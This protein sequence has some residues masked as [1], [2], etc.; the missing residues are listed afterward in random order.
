MQIKNKNSEFI[1][2]FVGRIINVSHSGFEAACSPV[3]GRYDW[4]INTPGA[5]GGPDWRFCK[6]YSFPA[7]TNSHIIGDYTGP[8]VGG[9]KFYNLHLM[10]GCPWVNFW[11][12]SNQN[13]V[14]DS[15]THIVDTENE[16]KVWL[17]V[18]QETGTGYLPVTYGIDTFDVTPRRLQNFKLVPGAQYEAKNI[19][20]TGLVFQ[21]K[22]LQV[23]ADGLLTFPDFICLANGNWLQIRNTTVPTEMKQ[24]E[25]KVT[26]AYIL[27]PNA[28]NP[29]NPSTRIAYRVVD[30]GGNSSAKP[31]VI[32]IYDSAGRSVRTLVNDVLALGE[33][34]VA[35]D[36]RDVS[37]KL[38]A[39]GV[40][41]VVFSCGNERFQRNIVLEK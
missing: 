39:S 7:L 32:R 27:P 2:G 12:L 20:K 9:E 8:A 33:Y 26:D 3:C 31:V 13:S 1:Y 36:G 19:L 6:N 4:Q 11:K 21:T 30:I 17:Q 24:L 38:C 25:K 22:T 14:P 23:G 10:W 15:C 5:N 16:Y 35:W 28:P 41:V 18:F 29:F 40:Y 34:A 37:D